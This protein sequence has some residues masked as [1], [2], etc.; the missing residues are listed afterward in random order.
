M[1]TLDLTRELVNKWSLNHKDKVLSHWFSISTLDE[2]PV[3]R[4]VLEVYC[5]KHQV[6]FRYPDSVLSEANARVEN[7]VRQRNSDLIDNNI[8]YRLLSDFIENS[9]YPLLFVNDQRVTEQDVFSEP[10]KWYPFEVFHFTDSIL[11]ALMNGLTNEDPASPDSKVYREGVNE[12]LRVGLSEDEILNYIDNGVL[13]FSFNSRDVVD[14]CVDEV[15][16]VLK[17]TLIEAGFYRVPARTAQQNENLWD[18]ATEAMIGAI[19]TLDLP[20]VTYKAYSVET[21][22]I[23]RVLNLL[24]FKG[25]D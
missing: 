9:T 11:I 22:D 21:K 16:H 7:E 24:E 19:K 4:M 5:S 25:V 8:H 13:S 2:T 3:Y 14:W 20:D 17:D 10:N 15:N 1:S 23:D 6:V 12:L 18:K